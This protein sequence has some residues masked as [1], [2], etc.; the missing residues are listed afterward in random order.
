M[1]R[2]LD[3]PGDL[4]A[5]LNHAAAREI[6]RVEATLA[7]PSLER[8]RALHESRKRL[9]KIRA[10]LH[11]LRPLAP[12]LMKAENQ[13]HRDIA[14]SLAG[15]REAGALVETIDRF[16][17]E[18]K[19]EDQAA[20]VP[21]RDFLVRR[22]DE[23]VAGS[24]ANLDEAIATAIASCRD[25]RAVLSAFSVKEGD[26]PARVIAE[27]AGATLRRARRWLRRAERH[28]H[29][30]DFHELRKAVKRHWAQLGALRAIWPGPVGQR[31]K[32][33]KMLG[34]KLG[35][36]NDIAV[37]RRVL[38]EMEAGRQG[39]D[40]A[41]LDAARH[42]RSLLDRKEKALRRACLRRARRL[43][44]LKPKLLGHKLV[45]SWCASPGS[46]AGA[47]TVAPAEAG[48]PA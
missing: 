31:R 13:R 17:A 38:D 9:K 30:E 26:D 34:E 10:L 29:I 1:V 7:D 15:P 44:D 47:Q 8:S 5:G 43:L 14:R 16:V 46:R 36:I 19:A 24:G 42:L 32:A 41:V 48:G 22:R 4:A 6:E 40:G 3:P 25:G 23:A 37:M 35:E 21:L 33:L 2:N 28:G 27:G 11:L 45:R 39:I 18:A 12:D 20:L